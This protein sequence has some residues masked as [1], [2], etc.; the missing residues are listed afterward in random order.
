MPIF[1]YKGVLPENTDINTVIDIGVY[2][3][4]G[5][6]PNIPFNGGTWGQLVVLGT[7]SKSQFITQLTLTD[8]HGFM[9]E[10]TKVTDWTQIF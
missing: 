5:A 2:D 6:Y 4:S 10:N 1:P 8:F 9:R 3:L 7:V